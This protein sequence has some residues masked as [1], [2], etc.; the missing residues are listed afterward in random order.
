MAEEEPKKKRGVVKKILKWI[1]VGVLGLLIILG[2]IFQAPWK[3]IAL[4]V[5]FLLAHTV[6]PRGGLKWFWAGVGVVV[7]ALIIW[8]FLPEDDTG[9]RPYTFD[10]ELA[11][12]E[13]KYA[14]PDE[15][16]AARIY[17]ELLES[18]DSN[19]YYAGLEEGEADK[20]PM[21]EPWLGEEHPQIAAWVEG[22]KTTISKLLSAA[23]MEE[24]RF[25]INADPFSLDDTMDRLPLMRKWAYLLISAVSNDMA[26]VRSGEGLKKLVTLLQMGKHQRQ[27]ASLVEFL[28]GVAIEALAIDQFKRFIVTGDATEEDLAAI[29]KTL[30]AIKYDWST[31]FPRFIEYEKLLHKNFLGMFYVVNPEGRIRLNPGVAMRAMIAQLPEDAKEEIGDKARLRYWR[32]KLMKAHTILA[33]FYMPSTPQKAA[34]I[35]DASFARYDAMAE[36]DF[37][38]QKEPQKPAKIFRLNYTYLVEHLTEVL[39]PAYQRIHEVYLRVKSDKRGSRIMVALRRYKNANGRWPDNLDEV[40]QFASEEIFIDPING[41]LFVYRLTDD[42]FILYSR[43]A[44][45]IDEGG[46]YE[47]HWPNEAQPDDRLIWPQRTRDCDTEEESADDEQ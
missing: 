38:W 11:A 24:C 42:G 7:I 46:L 9:W 1:G 31:D 13:A 43:G 28:V 21:R 27:Q 22:H 25:P 44:N 35:I 12:L 14:I 2:L 4:L 20:I 33:W 45:R 8:V 37:D 15:E 16:N 32:R 3:V 29:E 23:A 5:V 34:E 26:E 39:A 41:G 40:R 10:E 30:E 6:L 18:Y 17:N 36:P 19:S 47:S